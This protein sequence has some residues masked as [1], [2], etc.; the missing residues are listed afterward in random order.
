M[1]FDQDEI[2]RLSPEARVEVQDFYVRKHFADR[3]IATPERR[4][5]K[6]AMVEQAAHAEP[7]APAEER[8]ERR[9]WPRVWYRNDSSRPSAVLVNS[10]T[11]A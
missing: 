9:A 1:Q 3:H 4:G 7:A 2:D 10:V 8:E 5:R 11:S 6:R